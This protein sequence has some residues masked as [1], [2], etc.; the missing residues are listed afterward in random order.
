MERGPAVWRPS[1]G[2][3]HV[4]ILGLSMQLCK[5]FVFKETVIFVFWKFCICVCKPF[6]L[7]ESLTKALQGTRVQFGLRI[8][9]LS[10]LWVDNY[11][12]IEA[13]RTAQPTADVLINFAS[14]RSAAASS[15][16]ALKQP[17]I[18]VVAV[19]AEGVPE[20][21]TK[22]LIAYA[23]ANNKVVIGPATV[24]GIQAGVF[25][26]GDTAGTI[27]NIIH[28]KLYWPGFV[29]FVSKSVCSYPIS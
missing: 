28:R 4:P 14:Y 21:D 13:S 6:V 15:M 26:I 3:A 25:K 2:N 29:G 1:D 20:S 17:T 16:A 5:P 22:Q 12:N 18:R 11:C 7:Q 9:R 19:I 23:W 10:D 27:D 8:C 24:G